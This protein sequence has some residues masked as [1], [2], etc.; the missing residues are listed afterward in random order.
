MGTR[1]QTRCRPSDEVIHS[2]VVLLTSR[3]AAGREA[4]GAGHVLRGIS[5]EAPRRLPVTWREEHR[6]TTQHVFNNLRIHVQIF[7]PPSLQKHYMRASDKTE[8]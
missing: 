2:R 3:G 1:G 6:G 8:K 7:A 5:T 4:L